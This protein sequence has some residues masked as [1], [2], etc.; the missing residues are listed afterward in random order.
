MTKQ[1]VLKRLCELT[2]EVM[3]RHYGARVP[4]DC[5]C[6]EK[7]LPAGLKFEFSEWVIVFIEE[8]VTEAMSRKYERREC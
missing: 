7:I 6:T 3:T 8:A 5:F 1:E 4:A 2:T